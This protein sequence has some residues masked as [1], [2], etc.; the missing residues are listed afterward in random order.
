MAASNFGGSSIFDITTPSSQAS[1]TGLVTTQ[2]L[3][4]TVFVTGSDQTTLP[5]FAFDGYPVVPTSYQTKTLGGPSPSAM[6][7]CIFSPRQI[8]TATILNVTSQ[9]VTAAGWSWISAQIAGAAQLQ[10]YLSPNLV[11]VGSGSGYSSIPKVKAYTSLATGILLATFYQNV[12]TPDWLKPSA[13]WSYVATNSTAVSGQIVQMQRPITTVGAQAQEFMIPTVAPSS[14]D[15]ISWAMIQQPF[16]DLGL[17]VPDSTAIASGP[18]FGGVS[19]GSNEPANPVHPYQPPV[20]PLPPNPT[21]IVVPLPPWVPGT[22]PYR[23][24]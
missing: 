16:Y 9:G 1:V 20:N 11:T 17:R 8:G 10:S 19:T 7:S 22:G 4:V 18:S 23:R 24:H 5:T 15:Y 2:M 12:L 14:G 6:F 21:E 3:Q 13:T